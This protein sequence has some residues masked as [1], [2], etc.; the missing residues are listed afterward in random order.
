MVI[1]SPRNSFKKLKNKR[2]ISSKKQKTQILTH[3]DFISFVEPFYEL[4]KRKN[5]ENLKKKVEPKN[6]SLKKDVYNK[7]TDILNTKLLGSYIFKENLEIP[8][9]SGYRL[10]EPRKPIKSQ[11]ITPS[12]YEKSKILDEYRPEEFKTVNRQYLDQIRR[13][14][15]RREK[16]CEVIQERVKMSA[17][18]HLYDM[19][20]GRLEDIQKKR[21]SNKKMHKKSELEN[22]TITEYLYRINEFFDAFGSPDQFSYEEMNH[23]NIFESVVEEEEDSNLHFLK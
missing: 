6:F 11:L 7:L 1:G 19:I 15:E 16:I 4:L 14:N 5:F 12:F 18:F 23:P 13:N 20:N 3:Q 9:F 22:A 17:Y 21:I 8:D 10:L 2:K